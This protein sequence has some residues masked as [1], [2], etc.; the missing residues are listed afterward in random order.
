MGGAPLDE[1]HVANEINPAQIQIEQE[2][3]QEVEAEVIN[4]PVHFDTF[5]KA[6]YDASLM[7]TAKLYSKDTI[8]RST[9]QEV[10][11][12]TQ[13]FL[14]GFVSLLKQKVC[15]T[16]SQLDDLD[17]HIIQE[18]DELK[19]FFQVLE[20]PFEELDTETKRIAC[21]VDAK[22]FV[23]PEKYFIDSRVAPVQRKGI[24]Y[25]EMVPAY[26]QV[27]AFQLGPHESGNKPSLTKLGEDKLTATKFNLSG[28][29]SLCLTRYLGEMIGDLIPEDEPV[30]EYYLVLRDLLDILYAPSFPRGT[31]V[32]LRNK[33][34]E[35][36]E[37]YIETFNEHLK[38]VHHALLHYWRYV[39][40][41]GPL[42]HTSTSRYESKNRE[43]KIAAYSTESRVNIIVTLMIKNQLKMSYQFLLKNHFDLNFVSGKRS[44]CP[45]RI[46][47][48]F[49]A[50]SVNLNILENERVACLKFVEYGGT[51]YFIDSVVV[52]GITEDAPKFG[53]IESILIHGNSQLTFILQDF[54]VLAFNNHFSAYEVIE[55]GEILCR[56][57]AQLSNHQPLWLR[58]GIRNGVKF[59]SL[60]N[61]L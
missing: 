38:P 36:H 10:V 58:Y 17:E 50:F 11:N 12:Y 30:W 40:A 37:L 59:V 42:V 14:S 2:L 5:A 48:H 45:A 51:K 43:G 6:V 3:E 39:K 57:P 31:D 29:E 54:N 47:P 27:G 56:H 33:V 28:A 19:A 52:Y 26:G 25:M 55:N 7:F 18:V 32:F 22:V 61:A 13:D 16:F 1:L 49:D 9:V 41:V 46:V 34:R 24:M 44:H 21:L 8:P 60:R 20:S 4:D 23:P 53:K 35:H 15:H